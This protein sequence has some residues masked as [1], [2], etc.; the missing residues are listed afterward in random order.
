MAWKGSKH[1]ACSFPPFLVLDTVHHVFAQQ[2]RRRCRPFVCL[3]VLLLCFPGLHCS[4][5]LAC[6]QGVEWLV[7][8]AVLSPAH[9]EHSEEALFENTPFIPLVKPSISGR[10]RT[11]GWFLSGRCGEHGR[12]PSTRA[13]ALAVGC[14]TAHGGTCLSSTAGLLFDCCNPVS[15]A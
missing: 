1:S 15:V 13:D 7:S 3:H 8:L 14:E 10:Q 11:C 9:T 4:R 6:L 5:L 2:S 12:P